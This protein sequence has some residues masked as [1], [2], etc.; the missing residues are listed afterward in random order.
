MRQKRL[1]KQLSDAKVFKDVS[2]TENIT[3]KLSEVSKKKFSL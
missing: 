2:N 3:S 1:Q